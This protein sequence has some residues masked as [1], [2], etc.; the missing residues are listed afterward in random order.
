MGNDFQKALDVVAAGVVGPPSE[1][2]VRIAWI[3]N[4][5]RNYPDP[6]LFIKGFLEH[7]DSISIEQVNIDADLR[8]FD[9]IIQPLAVG[10]RYSLE[11]LKVQVQP[12]RPLQDYQ[13]YYAALVRPNPADIDRD[14]QSIDMR[15]FQ[16]TLGIPDAGY[17][18][19]ET[20]KEN[21]WRESRQNDDAL[22][23][24]ALAAETLL[25]IKQKENK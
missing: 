15:H 12:L 23:D 3:I 14:W 16:R 18:Q 7:P 1:D 25:E 24:L 9:I 11:E 4:K 5:K 21:E 2:T 10:N 17:L 6:T 8:S 13:Y 22:S 19:L 20:N